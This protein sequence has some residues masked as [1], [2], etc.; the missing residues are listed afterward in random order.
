MGYQE[1]LSEYGKHWNFFLTLASVILL[2]AIFSV[3]IAYVGWVGAAIAVVYEVILRVEGLQN[4]I[5]ESP[6]GLGFLSDN[7][8]GV[9]SLVGYYSLYLVAQALGAWL[10]QTGSQEKPTTR[11]QWWRRMWILF[12]LFV[13]LWFVQDVFF[14]YLLGMQPSRRLCNLGYVLHVLS[15]NCGLLAHLLL[16]DLILPV[17]SDPR[18][19]SGNVI[20]QAISTQRNSQLLVFI[21]ANLLTGLVNLSVRTL[22]ASPLTTLAILAAYTLAVSAVS[23]FSAKISRTLGYR[24]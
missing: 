10:L 3:P 12:F 24:S 22:F 8:E 19:R 4:W 23:V 17:P 9:F 7:R 18:I 13:G 5:F 14:E 21:V 1:H 2:D 15:C 20:L 16:L 11:A 6:R